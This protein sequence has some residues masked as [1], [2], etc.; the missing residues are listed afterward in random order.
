M[1][2]WVLPIDKM[3][4]TQ[5]FTM[6]RWQI[7]VKKSKATKQN[8]DQNNNKNRKSTTNNNKRH[9]LRPANDHLVVHLSDA[10]VRCERN[11]A[12]A[13]KFRKNSESSSFR[14]KKK[15]E[16]KQKMVCSKS[17][18]CASWVWIYSHSTKLSRALF[19]FVS[20]TPPLHGK[21]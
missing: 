15:K 5:I 20:V 21:S 1:H 9:L 18:P 8:K 7:V 12:K 14:R 4:I 2:A 6:A 10:V 13:A 19:P 16:D 17:L 11:T 3:K